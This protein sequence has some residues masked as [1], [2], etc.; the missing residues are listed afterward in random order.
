MNAANA[1]VEREMDNEIL[2][3]VPSSEAPRLS[4]L[5]ENIERNSH[6]LEISNIGLTF[7]S[8]EHVLMRCGIHG[9]M[10]HRRITKFGLF[11]IKTN[12]KVTRV[13]QFR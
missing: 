4:H 13:F 7:N 6:H 11:H 12:P 3:K 9:F 10:V 5:F 8:I 2:Y 1:T